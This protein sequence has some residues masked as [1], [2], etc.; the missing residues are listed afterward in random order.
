[1]E[2]KNVRL[3]NAVCEKLTAIKHCNGKDYWVIVHGVNSNSFYAYL[4]NS[5]GVNVTPVIS[6]LGTF[7]SN[8]DPELTIGCMKAT[9][10]GKQ[11]AIA[12]KRTSVD[13]LDFNNSAGV[14]S[15]A[16]PLFTPAD[17]Y[18]T[19]RGPYGVEFSPDSKLLYVSGDYFDFNVI[20]QQSFL[21]QYDVTQS[22]LFSI[23]NSKSVIY[24][25]QAYW[26]AENFGALQL[27]PDGKIY[28]AEME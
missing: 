1:M 17:T 2:V 27:A 21:L 28:L 9:Q 4:V 3:Q 6:S 8:V 23:Q 15:N 25:Q 26:A 14:L 24:T 19:M 11:I 22:T 12:H 18:Q 20:G 16:R 7:V 13:L 5:S 10:D